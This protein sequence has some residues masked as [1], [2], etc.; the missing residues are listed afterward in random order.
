MYERKRFD[1]FMIPGKILHWPSKKAR[2]VRER[3]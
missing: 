3:S 1:G 2:T